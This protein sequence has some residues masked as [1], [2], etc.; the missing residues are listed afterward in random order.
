M[1]PDKP[2]E[3]LMLTC[4]RSVHGRV[5]LWQGD[6]QKLEFTRRR[7]VLEFPKIADDKHNDYGY[8]WLVPM[9]KGRGLMFYYHGLTKGENSI[10]VT[11]IG[12]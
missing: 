9:E 2:G 4:E 8:T 5:V 7:T 12:Y 6:P 10:W 11:E 3:L 1:N